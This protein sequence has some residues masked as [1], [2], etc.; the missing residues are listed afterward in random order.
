MIT[1]QIAFNGSNTVT[2]HGST[3][4]DKQLLKLAFAGNT[5]A[6]FS[7]TGDSEIVITLTTTTETKGEL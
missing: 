1:V 5:M 3:E 6:G 7:I 2:L 4:R